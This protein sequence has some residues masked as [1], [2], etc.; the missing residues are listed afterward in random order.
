MAI[1]A[2]WYHY[3]TCLLALFEFFKVPPAPDLACFDAGADPSCRGGWG[4][5]CG[6]CVCTCS[7]HGRAWVKVGCVPRP[8]PAKW[9]LSV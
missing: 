9:K 4:G 2:Q 1:R 6:V 8:S 5:V 7:D 3:Q